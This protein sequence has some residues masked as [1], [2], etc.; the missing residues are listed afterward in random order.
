MTSV[1]ISE[2]LVAAMHGFA[3]TAYPEEC[4]GFLLSPARRRS[5][6]SSRR[7]VTIEPAP[8]ESE[9]ERRRRFVISPQELAS[10]E[11]RAERQ[12]HEVTGFYH[13]HPDHPARPSEFDQDH[14][15]PWYTYLILSI[16]G[17]RERGDL[18]AFELEPIRREFQDVALEIVPAGRAAVPAP[19]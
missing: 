19:R 9:G 10:A 7:V 18:G 16:R 8:N 11:A 1:A 12:G 14:A 2:E 17:D 13:S 3:A 5:Q 6:E 15:W 4:C